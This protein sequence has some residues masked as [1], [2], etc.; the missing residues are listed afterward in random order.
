MFRFPLAAASLVVAAALAPAADPAPELVALERRAVRPTDAGF[1]W[2]EIPWHTDAATALAEARKE[3][4][5]LFV[6]MAGGRDRD[7]TPLE[8]C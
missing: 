6:W 3:N 7:G 2:Q 8:R 5:P 1:R 4:R